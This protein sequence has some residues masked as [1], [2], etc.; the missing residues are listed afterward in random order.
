MYNVLCLANQNDLLSPE[1]CIFLS[2]V[3][4]LLPYCYRSKRKDS[5]KNRNHFIKNKLKKQNRIET[6]VRTSNGKQIIENELET[7][8]S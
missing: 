7:K 4:S 5:E 1:V 8:S 2:S 3:L 6:M